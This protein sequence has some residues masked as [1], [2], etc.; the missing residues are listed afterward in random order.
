VRLGQQAPTSLICSSRKLLSM[1][2][3][4]AAHLELQALSL[5]F[6]AT[7]GR[8]PR[9][10]PD[11]RSAWI[12]QTGWAELLEL[13]ASAGDSGEVSTSILRRTLEVAL[14]GVFGIQ[15]DKNRVVSI[16]LSRNGLT[17][18]LPREIANLRSLRSLKLRDNPGLRGVLPVNFLTHTPP[19]LRYCYL[20]G[21]KIERVLPYTSAHSLEVTRVHGSGTAVTVCF[22][23]GGRPHAQVPT[24][25][26]STHWTADVAESELFMM[27]TSLVAV[28]E[29]HEQQ[30]TE[31]GKIAC[32]AANATGPER[33]AAATKL[34]RIYRARIERTKFRRFLRSLFETHVDPAS[35]YRYFVDTRTGMASWQR[36]AFLST[37]RLGDASNTSDQSSGES[38][39][40]GDEWQPYDDGNGNTVSCVTRK[41]V[42]GGALTLPELGSLAQYYWNRMTGE[43]TWES[44]HM[45]SRLHAE[46]VA[47]Y[48]SDKTDAER[49]NLFFDEIDADHT[50]EIDR[51][52]FARLCGDLGMAMST[53]QI[54]RAFRELDSSGDGQLS[55][56][57]I[58]AWL[59][60]HFEG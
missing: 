23:T 56:Q 38:T 20:D 30:Q 31:P 9:I 15:F 47:R 5:L 19:Q 11:E 33:I 46:L 42:R 48:G 29:Q 1:L 8:L 3:A 16:D 50:G 22:R 52:E 49:L 41:S 17:G 13:T 53:T 57:E 4:N 54:D 26:N 10:H 12:N 60:H 55:R 59:S 14:P 24:L 45:R 40:S 44:P 39:A 35:G 21:T 27:H 43:S 28:R 58:F 34:Q 37:P 6:H 51:D 18:T 25:A 2:D 32:T 7:G 36:P